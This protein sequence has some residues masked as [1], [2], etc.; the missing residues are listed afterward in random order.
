MDGRRLVL[1]HDLVSGLDKSEGRLAA[2]VPGLSR[3]A[4]LE[5]ATINAAYALHAD[6]VTG[7][8]EIGKF[9][10]LMVLDRNPLTVPVEEI[11][12]VQVLETVVVGNVVYQA[13]AAPR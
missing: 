3:E 1:D 8:L 12:K 2:R 6:H 11:G 4:V 13:R 5:A 10:D 7:S 9:A